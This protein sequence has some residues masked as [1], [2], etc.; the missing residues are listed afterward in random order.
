MY[1]LMP[2]RSN[3]EMSHKNTGWFADP[4]F[5]RFFDMGDWFGS[6]AFRVDV[7]DLGDKYEL[8]AELPGV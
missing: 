4:L 8:Q 7:M 3:K 6:S 2:Y 1:T 5:D